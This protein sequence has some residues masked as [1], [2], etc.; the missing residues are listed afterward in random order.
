MTVLSRGRLAFP[1]KNEIFTEQAKIIHHRPHKVEF[2]LVQ[3]ES[4]GK[5]ILHRDSV[6]VE[7]NSALLEFFLADGGQ[8]LTGF[9]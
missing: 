7:F 2:R 1:M 5:E 6:L 3:F 9:D 4:I 8:F